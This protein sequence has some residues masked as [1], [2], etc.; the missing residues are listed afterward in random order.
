MDRRRTA[1]LTAI[2]VPSIALGG[3][4]ILNGLYQLAGSFELMFEFLRLGF[5]EIPAGRLTFS[6]LIL[7]I[8]VLGL[9]AGVGMLARRPWARVL[10][11]VFGG[12]LIVSAVLSFFMVPI[13]ATIGTYDVR[14]IGGYALMRLIIYSAIYVLFPALYSV[15]LFIVVRSPVWKIA[16]SNASTVYP[17]APLPALR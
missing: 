9:T 6:L 17:S 12:L 10:S 13:I 11:L 5:F 7:T 8:G 1:R 14:S 15:V 2:V 4:E 16:F 3:L